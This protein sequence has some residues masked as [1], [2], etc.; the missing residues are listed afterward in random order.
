MWPSS[1]SNLAASHADAQPSC[2]GRSRLSPRAGHREKSGRPDHPDVAS[3][4]TGLG[5]LLNDANRFAE[6]EPLL[7]RVL[8]INEKTDGLNTPKSPSA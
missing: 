7:R 8:A 4:L 2:R 1:L 3:S 6:A 5:S